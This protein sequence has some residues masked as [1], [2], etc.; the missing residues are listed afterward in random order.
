MIYHKKRLDAAFAEISEAS[1]ILETTLQ[2]LA[3]LDFKAWQN[4]N[5]RITNNT[6]SSLQELMLIL[7]ILK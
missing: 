7:T 2:D 5:E 1:K 6:G 4:L 3:D